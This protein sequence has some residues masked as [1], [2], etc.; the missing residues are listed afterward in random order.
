VFYGGELGDEQVNLFH[1]C[2]PPLS[3]NYIGLGGVDASVL[4]FDLK[5]RFL[6]GVMAGVSVASGSKV[7]ESLIC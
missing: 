2:L 6:Q 3:Q 1:L 5:A 4:N 7:S